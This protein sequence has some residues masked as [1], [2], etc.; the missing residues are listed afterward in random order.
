MV[1][2]GT[3]LHTTRHS[4]LVF[5]V[6]I[7]V[8]QLVKSIQEVILLPALFNYGF[9]IHIVPVLSGTVAIQFRLVHYLDNFNI[10]RSITSRSYNH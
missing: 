2:S 6:T 10:S 1:S 3:V 4:I 5:G 9:P 8:I 7:E